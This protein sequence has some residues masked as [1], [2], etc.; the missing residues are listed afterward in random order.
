MELRAWKVL[1]ECAHEFC[2][3]N[4]LMEHAPGMCSRGP[5]GMISAPFPQNDL[6]IVLM[7]CAHEFCSWNVLMDLSS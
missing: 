6:M 2:S 1:M 5:R 7:A 3:W 4:V